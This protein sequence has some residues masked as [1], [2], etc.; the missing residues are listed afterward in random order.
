MRIG[1]DGS[2]WVNQRG[3]GRFTRC[4]V[5][6]MV[7]RHPH[8]DYVLVMDEPSVADG[9]FPAGVA[10]RSVPVGSSPVRAAAADGSRRLFD[11]ARMAYAARQVAS[12]AYFFPASYSYYPVPGRVVVVTVHDAIAEALPDLVVPGRGDRLRW[13]LKQK[14]ALRQARHVITVSQAARTEV[15]QRL[16]VNPERLSVV[17]EAPAPIF[18]PLGRRLVAERIARFGLSSEQKYLIY[19]G[20]ISPHKNLVRLIQAFEQVRRDHPELMLILVGEADDDPF[21][22][23][24]ASVRQAIAS[25]DAPQA[26]KFTGYVTDEEL[27]ALYSGAVASVLPSLG[28]GYGLTAAES[29]A[30]GT[31]VVASDLPAL[32]ELLGA[33]GVFVDPLDPASIVDGLRSV[34][35]D[36]GRRATKASAGLERAKSWSWDSAADTVIDVLERAAGH[37]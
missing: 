22:S 1:I 26:V 29:V 18:A 35:A 8:H 37:G 33:A 15:E 30:C 5:N 23:S 19:V 11:M 32:R 7:A 14:T 10:V 2:C 36:E 27:V 34:V 31:P 20:G 17:H 6:Q 25:T 24:T 13:R 16:G 21:L 28:E 12:E 3:F 9:G 4:L